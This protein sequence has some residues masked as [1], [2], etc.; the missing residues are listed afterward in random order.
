[1][2]RKQQRTSVSLE[3]ILEFASGRRMSRLSDLSLGGCYVDS[4]VAAREGEKVSLSIKIGEGEWMGLNAEVAY[5]FAGG[6]FGLRFL[7]LSETDISLLE[8]TI[9]THGGNPW[10]K[11]EV[12]D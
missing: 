11:G 2:P 9:L 12:E 4:I 3:V 8:H 7:D 5:V 1:M 10:A 6:G